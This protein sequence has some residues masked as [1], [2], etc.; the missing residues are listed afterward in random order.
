VI[1]RPPLPSFLLIFLGLG[2]ARSRVAEGVGGAWGRGRER[3]WCVLEIGDAGRGKRSIAIFECP[4]TVCT[5]LRDPHVL[6]W[7]VSCAKCTGETSLAGEEKGGTYR[8]VVRTLAQHQTA[9]FEKP[10]A[11]SPTGQGGVT[12]GLV[13]I[14]AFSASSCAVAKRK[15]PPLST[16]VQQTL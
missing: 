11:S 10:G 15:P 6:A 12:D 3:G 9:L 4:Y 16:P 13:A 5:E 1:S 8:I 14:L 7:Y 2:A